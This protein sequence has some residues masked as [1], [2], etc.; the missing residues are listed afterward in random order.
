MLLI[1]DLPKP[2]IENLESRAYALDLSVNAF[3]SHLLESVLYNPQTIQWRADFGSAETSPGLLAL[4]AEIEALPKESALFEPA[5][6]TVEEFF[7]EDADASS[8]EEPISP[9]K[10]NRLW[11][12]FEE[13][14]KEIDS[15]DALSDALNT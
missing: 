14:L 4:I 5:T 3:T 9:A 7:L 15:A 1:L 13:E 8:G 11:A 12:E 2:I 10:W 6:K